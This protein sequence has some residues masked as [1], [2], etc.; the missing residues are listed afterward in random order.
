MVVAGE[1]GIGKSTLLDHFVTQADR[2]RAR[3]A[4]P[5][6][7]VRRRAAVASPRRRPGAA[8]GSDR[9]GG[10]RRGAGSRAT[11]PRSVARSG[12]RDRS[13]GR[14]RHRAVAPVRVAAH[15]L[16]SPG[17]AQRPRGG[18][19][20]TST[21]PATRRGT[22]CGSSNGGAP[23]PRCSSSWPREVVSTSWRR[24][25]PWSSGRS[26]WRRRPRSWAPSAPASC[27]ARQRGAPP[28]P[29]RAGLGTARSA[30]RPRLDPGRGGPTAA[31]DRAR[32]RCAVGGGRARP[33]RPRP[34]RRRHRTVADRRAR[35]PRG[36]RREGFLQ[37][38]GASYAFRHALVREALTAEVSA[39]RRAWLHRSAA[40]RLD[41]R[42]PRGD[43]AEIVHHA[44][45]GGE[46]ALTARALTGTAELAM[47][48]FA[49]AEAVRS[50]DE[51]IELDDRPEARLLR[52]R[53]RIVRAD[54]AGAT[55][56]A[57]RA[58]QLGGGAPGHELA[59][60]A[61]YLARRP[62]RGRGARAS[63]GPGWRRTRWCGPAA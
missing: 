32:R 36:R 17:P 53:A 33:E 61:A 2:R 31:P 58:I 34:A 37:E 8:P 13:A 24:R 4:G 46:A 12:R 42:R 50:L 23:G 57:R 22:G 19:R 25:P 1:A 6:R 62:A 45:L 10:D 11:R 52:G 56:D 40:I 21:S 9:A 43:L 59:S 28:V 26:T 51:A 3:P 49:Y 38:D 15:R 39:A 29:G 63:R 60:W 7:R 41:A 44:R 55:E 20:T 35:R 5:V 54:V 47:S 18:D 14:R 16:R 30:W 27:S 48:R